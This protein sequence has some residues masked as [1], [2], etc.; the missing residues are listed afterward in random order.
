MSIIFIIIIALVF[1]NLFFLV[2]GVI[3]EN[4]EKIGDELNLIDYKI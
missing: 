2:N 1:Q 4:P 3:T